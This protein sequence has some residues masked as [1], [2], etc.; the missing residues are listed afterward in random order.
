MKIKF[1]LALVVCVLLFGCASSA[2]VSETDTG[3]FVRNGDFS[4]FGTEWPNLPFNWS[5]T[6]KGGDGYEPIKTEDGRFIGWAENIYSFTLFQ[7]ISGLTEG[8]YTLSAEFRLNP[9]STAEDIVMNVY[10]GSTLLKSKSVRDELFAAPRETDVL[11]ELNDIA[12]SG[13]SVKIE[14]AGTNILKYVGIDNV[15]FSR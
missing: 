10:S 15:V 2:Q 12:V 3:N 1:V 8:T 4:R 13:R 14:F 7:N 5:T 9:D 11:F 6:W